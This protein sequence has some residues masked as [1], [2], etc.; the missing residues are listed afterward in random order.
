MSRDTF[1]AWAVVELFGHRQLIGKVQEA[2]IG[3]ATFIRVD[4]LDPNKPGFVTSQMYSPQAIYCITPVSEEVARKKK[5]INIQ[6]PLHQLVL[7]SA[8][9]DPERMAPG[10]RMLRDEEQQEEDE[11]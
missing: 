9:I 10:V 7:P 6:S 8:L 3:G 2:Q 5:G 1:E 11:Y 4:V